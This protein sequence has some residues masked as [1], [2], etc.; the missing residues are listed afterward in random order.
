MLANLA[1][2]LLRYERITTTFA[3]AADTKRVV[4][5][6]IGKAKKN[7][8]AARRE[9]AKIIRDKE[10]LKKLFLQVGPQFKARPGGYVRIIRLG[11]RKGDSA[12]VVLMELVEKVAPLPEAQKEKPKT[13]PKEKT[14]EALKEKPKDIPQEKPKPE[15]KEEPKVKAEDK[16]KEIVEEKPKKEALPAK[17][18]PKAE[19]KPE[20]K[21]IPP[22]EKKEKSFFKKLFRFKGGK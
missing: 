5:K 20:K 12:S 11:Q 19:E 1:M 4:E 9:A 16:L 8:L 3:K 18:E 21:E 6:L 2:S 13:K 22:A 14:E 15:P 7:T 17:P 10:V